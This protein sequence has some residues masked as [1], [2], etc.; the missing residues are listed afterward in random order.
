MTTQTKMLVG[1]AGGLAAGLL[2]GFLTAPE[3]GGETRKKVMDQ[4]GKLKNGLTKLMRF[5]KDGEMKE[6]IENAT[7]SAI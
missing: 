3:K 7:Q 6:E 5:N 4:T 2:L 1:I